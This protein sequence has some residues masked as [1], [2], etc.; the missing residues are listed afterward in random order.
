[1][2]LWRSCPISASQHEIQR[3]KNN[4]HTF[5]DKIND[6]CF[7]PRSLLFYLLYFAESRT[8]RLS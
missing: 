8:L 5:P 6:I 2:R 3:S 1:M 4:S 7:P